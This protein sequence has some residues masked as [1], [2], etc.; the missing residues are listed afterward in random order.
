MATL[1]NFDGQM[2][3]PSQLRILRQLVDWQL[4]YSASVRDVIDTAWQ[5]K[6][7]PHKKKAEAPKPAPDA[8]TPGSRE[9]LEVKPLGQDKER[10]RFWVADGRHS[11]LS[12]DH[13]I[14]NL[15]PQVRRDYI[16]RLTHGKSLKYSNVSAPG[17]KSTLNGSISYVKTHLPSQR[18]IWQPTKSTKCIGI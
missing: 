17:W 18:R 15:S 10:T 4:A 1:L 7:K 12:L 11:R 2:L 8:G 9:I 6:Q 3:T 13:S 16:R 14:C 5:V